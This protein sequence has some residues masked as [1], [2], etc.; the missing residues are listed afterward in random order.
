MIRLAVRVRREDADLV[1]ILAAVD[2]DSPV[3][4]E[5]YAAVAEILA[6]LYR[7]NGEAPQGFATAQPKGPTF[8]GSAR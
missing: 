5:A 6:Y 1:Q 2:V 8:E 7:A 3:P 4:T